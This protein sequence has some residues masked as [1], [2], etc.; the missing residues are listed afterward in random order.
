MLVRFGIAETLA[1]KEKCY[2]EIARIRG[3][4]TI[5]N[6]SHDYYDVL[7]KWW[8]LAIRELVALPDAKNSSKWIARARCSRT[9]RPGRRHILSGCSD[10]WVLSANMT[11]GGIRR[12]RPSKPIRPSNRLKRRIFIGRWYN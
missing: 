11:A 2:Q 8:H 10:G 7:D 6:L 9:F 12:T 5:K 1:E 4:A 3:K